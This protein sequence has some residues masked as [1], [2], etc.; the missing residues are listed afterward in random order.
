MNS[1]NRRY[2]THRFPRSPARSIVQSPEYTLFKNTHQNLLIIIFNWISIKWWQSSPW[3]ST[4]IQHNFLR[5]VHHWSPAKP[6]IFELCSASPQDVT[7]Y[8]GFENVTLIF[9]S[10]IVQK[11]RESDFKWSRNRPRTKRCITGLL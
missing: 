6:H 2:D 3:Y 11:L 1:N 10:P 4:N 5:Q 8:A 7:A 9:M